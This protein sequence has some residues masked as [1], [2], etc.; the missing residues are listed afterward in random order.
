MAR[1]GDGITRR[2]ERWIA[3]YRGTDG[4]EHARRFDRKVD[5]ERWRRGEL[6]KVDRGEW[7][8]PDAWVQ[9]V[10]ATP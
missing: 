10:V 8:D 9:G 3:S 7:I 4:Q 5:A 2:G 6:A 1:R